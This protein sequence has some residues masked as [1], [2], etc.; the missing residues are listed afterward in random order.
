MKLFSSM[1]APS[2]EFS[3]LNSYIA[4]TQPNLA[5]ISLSHNDKNMNIFTKY[6]SFFSL[7]F[8]GMEK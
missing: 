4:V 8:A 3:P 7:N 2:Q 6:Y 5:G 1:H